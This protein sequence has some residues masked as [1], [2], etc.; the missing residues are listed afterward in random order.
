MWVVVAGVVVVPLRD[1]N[2]RDQ[3]VPAEWMLRLGIAAGVLL[4]AAAIVAK[5]KR[6]PR[7]SE[8][9]DELLE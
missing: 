2:V 3:N 6:L 4:A 9:R 5:T 8:V 7:T 1:Q